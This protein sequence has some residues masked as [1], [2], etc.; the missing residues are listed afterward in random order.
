VPVSLGGVS[1]SFDGIPAPLLYVSSTQINVQVR[2]DVYR[3]ASTVMQVSFN[4]SPIG[5]GLF[6]ITQTN[7]NLF[8]NSNGD[9]FALNQD[10]S[11]NS[12][13]NPA[14][15]GSDV[16]LFVNGDNFANGDRT[17]GLIVGAV[18][19]PLYVPV[20]AFGRSGRAQHT[21]SDRSRSDRIDSDS[22]RSGGRAV[23]EPASRFTVT[24]GS[25]PNSP[26]KGPCRT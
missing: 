3:S 15:D 8:L 2:F 22:E 5:S 1:V 14:K 4:G 9:A 7:P 17:T 19:N 16:L 11:V 26:E 24:S 18:L 13:T 25:R 6:A 10:G 21:R 23:P 20:A 12:S